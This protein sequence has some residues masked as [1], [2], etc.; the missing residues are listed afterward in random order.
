[1]GGKFFTSRQPHRIANAGSKCVAG[2]VQLSF[3]FARDV[4]PARH[5]CLVDD[6]GW[7]TVHFNQR[8]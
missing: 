4:S 6:N 1:M 2:M 5:H 7:K 8:I 3:G